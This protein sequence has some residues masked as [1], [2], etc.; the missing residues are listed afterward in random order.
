MMIPPLL[1]SVAILFF[2]IQTGPA[3]WIGGW[4][5]EVIRA[6]KRKR[7]CLFV[8]FTFFH[9]NMGRLFIYR[10]G[11]CFSWNW[12]PIWPG[13]F[14]ILGFISRLECLGSLAAAGSSLVVWWNGHEVRRSVELA[15]CSSTRI[16]D[17]DPTEVALPPSPCCWEETT[18]G[19]SIDQ[20]ELRTNT[21]A[22]PTVNHLSQFA[23][24]VRTA[25][26]QNRLVLRRLA[27]TGEARECFWKSR[28]R[29]EED[30]EQLWRYKDIL[31]G[32]ARPPT[33]TSWVLVS[34]RRTRWNQAGDVCWPWFFCG[35]DAPGDEERWCYEKEKGGAMK[36]QVLLM[37][38]PSPVSPFQIKCWR[39][40]DGRRRR[41][42]TRLSSFQP[43]E[44]LRWFGFESERW[45]Q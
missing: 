32:C 45:S 6:V 15:L 18:C 9:A 20:W 34:W 25:A 28:R 13:I 37:V 23:S 22:P 39:D 27:I 10:L 26:V 8:S 24:A 12:I 3:Y 36:K 2:L 44:T 31:S 29:R 21:A 35:F 43:S 41:R 11:F 38:S 14:K 33:V 17:C 40:V 30:E 1:R 42:S 7:C 16:L 19:L 5:L 4:I